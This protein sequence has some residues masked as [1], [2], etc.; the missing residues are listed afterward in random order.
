MRARFRG[1]ADRQQKFLDD[2]M[3]PAPVIGELAPGIGEEHRA[4]GLL[5]DEL[6][7]LQPPQ[8]LDDRRRR[9]AKPFG[10]IGAARFAAFVDEIGDQ[11]DIILGDLALVVGPHPLKGL[12][13]ARSAF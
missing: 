9:N 4:V 13:V 7:V 1:D 6:L 8:C 10:D 11:F 2:H 5:R 3:P 12:R